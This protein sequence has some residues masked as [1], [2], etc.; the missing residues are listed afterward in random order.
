MEE[1]WLAGESGHYLLQKFDIAMIIELHECCDEL[2]FIYVHQLF[3]SSISVFI[4]HTVFVSLWCT[5]IF[6]AL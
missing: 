5:L 1:E 3:K 2:D 4:I 6:F